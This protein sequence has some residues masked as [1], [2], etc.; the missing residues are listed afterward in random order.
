MSPAATPAPVDPADRLFVALDHPSV[1]EARA[2]VAKLEGVVRRF[3][4]GSAVF[5]R[6]GPGFVEELVARDLGVF[7]DLKFHDTP[8]TVAGAVAAAA[9]LGVEM[10]TLHA[11]GGAG[12]L[13]A[14]REAADEAVRPPGLIAV[15]VLTSIDP[16]THARIAG[17]DA[18]GVEE[19]VLALGRLAIEAGVDGLVCSP[20]EVGAL[21]A[22]LGGGPLLVVPGI[23]PEWTSSDH[24]GQARTATPASAIGAGAS[25]LVVGRAITRA[26]D[27]GG[28]ARRVLR[29][30]G[31][32]G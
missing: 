3:K 15:T 24:A 2:C 6:A 1:E 17:P 31:A 30:I 25:A 8:N 12:M 26:P 19:S 27:P 29:V 18:R 13:R 20:R 23:R 10:L 28:A 16:E 11:A 9:D 7:L 22:E 32:A 5:T 4:V 14:A 21:R